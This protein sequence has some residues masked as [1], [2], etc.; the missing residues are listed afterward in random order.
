MAPDSTHTAGP[1][2]ADHAE[3]ML[4]PTSTWGKTFAIARSKQ[5]A[6]EP[7][8]IR[9][10]AQK[11]STAVT[12]SPAPSATV[13][14]NCANLGPGEFCDVKIQGDTAISA[15]EPVLVGHYLESAMWSDGFLT[16]VGTGDPSMAVAVPVEQY[17]TDYTVLI[18]SAY[19]NNY[20]SISAP[21]SGAVTVDGNAQT[22]TSFASNL[23]RSTIVTVGAGQHKISC[24]GTC[25][26]LVYGYDS[27]VSYMFAGGLDLKQIVVQ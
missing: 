25:G 17:R 19:A 15:S 20:L 21:A 10:M 27:A 9:V 1:C 22:L 23:Y 24:P 16:T 11:A 4:F 3:E 13:A 5:R 14:G 8:Y 12:F 6:G 7:D 2:C 18:P 26:V